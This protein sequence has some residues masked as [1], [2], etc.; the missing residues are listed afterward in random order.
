MSLNAY[1]TEE[2]EMAW[3]Q[4]FQAFAS[5]RRP[6]VKMNP[7][8]LKP[9]G[10]SR[11]E[12]ILLGRPEGV[13]DSEG[14]KRIK[15]RFEDAVFSAFEEVASGSDLVVV[16][17]AGSVAELNLLP[18][19]LANYGLL[20]RYEIPYVLISDIERGG[21][22]AQ[23]WGTYQLIPELKDLS[24]GFV[25]NKFRGDPRLFESGLRMLEDLTGVPSL[26]VLPYL[27][28][29]FFEEDGAS[30]RLSRGWFGSDEDTLRVAVVAYPFISNFLDFDPLLREPGVELVF[31]RDPSLARWAHLVVLP[32]SRNTAES[33]KWLKET[34]WTKVLRKK[35]E[36]GVVLGICGGF[37]L[38]GRSLE[39]PEGVEFCGRVEGLGLLPHRTLY[40]RPK[41][42]GAATKDLD[43]PFFKGRAKGFEIRY[44][45]SF[46]EEKEVDHLFRDGVF[47]WY[48]HGLFF[49]DEFRQAFLN[50][51]RR[52]AGLGELPKTSYLRR[53]EEDMDRALSVREFREFFYSLER[54]LFR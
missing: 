32:G 49:D 16:E 36:E 50:F 7:V 21:V 54:S 44:G 47:G 41:I 24:L 30:L 34:G 13:V 10:E 1:A 3:A 27:S 43:L 14:F 31:T 11:S 35:A 23:V 46:V 51:L 2:G 28:E 40:R 20:R 39:D 25:V 19:D 29:V 17:G 48:L 22:F 42:A 18:Y 15:S 52:K 9:L 12:L 4:A 45:R 26:G 8:L 5:G 33:L 37:Q 53:V 38:L 6:S